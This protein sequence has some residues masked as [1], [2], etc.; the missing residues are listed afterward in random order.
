MHVH[1]PRRQRQTH[2]YTLDPRPRRL[3]PK[4]RPAIMHKVELDIPPPP[5][6]LPL[7]FRLRVRHVLAPLDQRHVAR[8][9]RTQT[10]LDK[11]EEL[12]LV[13]FFD[14]QVVE[15]YAAHAARFVAVRDVEVFVAPGL[16][17]R[18]VG[19]VMLVA[20][21]LD[22]TVEVDRVLVEQIAGREIGPAAEPPCVARPGVFIHGLEI[23]VVEM[24]RRR[25]GVPGV[26]HQTQPR[27]EEFQALDIWIQRFVVDAHFL[28]GGPRQRA[29]HDGGVDAGFF[30]DAAVL[31]DAA[32]AAATGG[33]GPRVGAEFGGGVEGLEGGDDGGLRGFNR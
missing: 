33:A 2:Q 6:L 29:V 27:G 7:L 31:Q 5:Q 1:P 16:E 4:R 14:V 3:Q 22:G 9:E 28:D 17:A 12:L 20:C 15:E 23:A 21:L 11:R 26:Q 18:E 13:F 19:A 32:Y 25:H 8:Q 30:E 10:I 24:H